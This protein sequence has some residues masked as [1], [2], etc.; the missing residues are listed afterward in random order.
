MSHSYFSWT[1]RQNILVSIYHHVFVVARV[2][3]HIME[4]MEQWHQRELLSRQLNISTPQLKW[5]SVFPLTPFPAK[6]QH[7][8]ELFRFQKFSWL[9]KCWW[10]RPI[11][12][13][14]QKSQSKWV[15]KLGFMLLKT[16]VWMNKV[17]QDLSGVNNQTQQNNILGKRVKVTWGYCCSPKLSPLTLRNEYGRPNRPAVWPPISALRLETWN[18]AFK[19]LPLPEHRP[20]IQ[21]A[22]C[23]R[24]SVC[25]WTRTHSKTKS[26]RG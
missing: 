26:S 2:A 22:K 4:K 20:F 21:R 10:G 19:V 12:H 24:A 3:A 1:R 11:F 14:R 17:P 18:A 16:S 13:S 25:A 15:Q 7:M 5:S 6:N 8:I 9:C 23:V